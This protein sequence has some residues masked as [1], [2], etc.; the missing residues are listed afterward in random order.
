MNNV[1]IFQLGKKLFANKMCFFI[2]H[3]L[4]TCCCYHVE[5]PE[6]GKIVVFD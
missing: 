4:D 2:K 5:Y 6:P 3:H 1:I